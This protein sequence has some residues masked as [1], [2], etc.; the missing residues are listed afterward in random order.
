M[1]AVLTLNHKR[2]VW[3]AEHYADD[4][5]VLLE[6]WLQEDF[7]VDLQDGSALLV[8]KVCAMCRSDSCLWHVA[9]SNF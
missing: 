7:N 2:V 1:S 9:Q 5:E 6:A 3:P 4:L 8:A